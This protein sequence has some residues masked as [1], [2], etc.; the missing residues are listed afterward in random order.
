[1]VTS[2]YGPCMAWHTVEHLWFD[3]IICRTLDGPVR[4]TYGCHTGISNVFH[5]LRDP[6]RAHAGPARH[7]MALLWTCKG[8]DT[9]RICKN[10]VR[11]PLLFLHGLV[12]ISK[13]HTGPHGAYDACIKTLR[14]GKIN[15]APYGPHEWTY[16]FCSKQPGNSPYGHIE[17][18]QY[19]L[20]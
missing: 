14:G 11:D 19:W 2:G 4:C 3:R 9:T 7:R 20:R 1:M 12:T 6:N 18:S 15:T 17:L 5:I 13:T 8:T 16:D 10:P